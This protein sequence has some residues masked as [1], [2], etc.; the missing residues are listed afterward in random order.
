MK[1]QFL[2]LAFGLCCALGGLLGCDP[3]E[4][5]LVPEGDS[6]TNWLQTCTNDAECGDLS[7]LYGLCTRAC[8]D[9]S[10]CQPGLVCSG[11]ACLPEAGGNV[12]VQVDASTRLQTLVG[13][14]ATIG[15]AEDELSALSDRTQLDNALFA[16]LGLDVLRVRSRYAEVSDAKLAQAQELVSA[17]ERSLGRRPLVLL[18]S[19]SPPAALKQNGGTFCAAGPATC[20]LSQKAGGGFDYA[21]FAQHWRSALTAYARVGFVPD[22]VGI[23]NNPDWAPAPGVTAE[24]CKFLPTEGDEDALVDGAL[25]PV[26]YPGFAEALAA[27]ASAIADL[28]AR[29]RLLAPEL[30]GVRGAERYFRT[31]DPTR[32]D[33]IAHHLYGSV[34]SKPDLLGMTALDQLGSS[35]ALPLFQTEMQAGGLDTALLIHHALVSEGAAMY[36]QTALVAPRSGPAANPFALVGLEQGEFVLQEPYFAVQHY[37]LFTDPGY[38]RVPAAVSGGDVL[39]SAWR[40]PAGAALTVVLINA[41]TTERH[42]ALDV[43]D[44]RP[45]ELW[46]TAFDGAERMADLGQ[47]ASDAKI[48]LPPRSL[49]TARFE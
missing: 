45:F 22:Y 6:H 48:T 7:C 23:Q 28:P 31:L 11:G 21:A 25:E 14:G 3:S 46:R 18:S 41:A 49:A 40:A 5:E 36:L 19:W 1:Q 32:V 8:T 37:A 27:V 16:G 30:A 4:P 15:Y 34:A 20:T 12:H 10:A 35:M 26:H 17:A 24:A 33:A 47:M 42:V 9:D 38:T 39:V 29:P 2:A 44:V 13:F 43:G